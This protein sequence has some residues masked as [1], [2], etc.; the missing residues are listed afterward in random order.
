MKTLTII[1]LRQL[2][3]ITTS[4]DEEGEFNIVDM[5]VYTCSVDP[6]MYLKYN[7][8][9]APAGS[10]PRFCTS[11]CLEKMFIRQVLLYHL[12]DHYKD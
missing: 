12:L 3:L 7:G 5:T 2:I 1:I 6:Y 8:S 4:Y 9:Q 11:L 10:R